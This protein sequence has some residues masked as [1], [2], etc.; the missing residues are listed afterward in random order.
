MRFRVLPLIFLATFSQAAENVCNKQI[1]VAVI[2]TGLDLTDPRFT[3]HLCKT[4]HYNFVNGESINDVNGHGTFVA[5]LI[6]KYAGNTNYCMVIYKYY[7]SQSSGIINMNREVQALQLAVKN[8]VRIV[9]FS[10]GG[11]SFS[12]QE[13]LLIRFNPK[14]TF[15][16]AAGN[17]GENLDLPGNT[18]YPASLFYSN[19]E[20]VG[21]IDSNGE[22]AHTS[23]YGHMI[24]N[25]E[26]GEKV[27]SYLP[28]D[29]TGTMSGTSF[30]TAIFTGKLVDKLSKQCEHRK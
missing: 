15:V 2:D 18:F 28:N 7:N 27:V 11:P 24:K 1:K 23:N 10:G 20:I 22:K 4:G 3:D 19:E 25:K 26:I 8:K 30:S 21:S 14:T 12:E 13:S 29:K 17:E 6:E 16:V 5:G 9:N